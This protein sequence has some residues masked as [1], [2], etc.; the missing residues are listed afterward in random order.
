MYDAIIIGAGMSGLAA[1]IR[2]AHYDQRVCILE[3]HSVIG[4]LN[5]FYRR[6][7]RNFDVGLHA[8]TNYAPKGARGGPLGRLLRQ[9]RLAWDELSLVPQTGSAICF[10]GVSLRFTNDFERLAADVR[11]CF[12]RQED[13]LRRLVASLC[14]YD[15]FADPASSSSARQRV[16]EFIRDP[17]LR[18]M[19]LCP[20]LF[21]GGAR[22]HDIDFGQFSILFRS[23]FLEGLARPLSGVKQI[24]TK[25]V[26]RFRDLGGE[27]RLRCGVR[28]IEV[29]DGAAEKVVLDDGTELAA[30]RIL[31]SAGLHE[32]LR[33]CDEPAVPKADKD[34]LSFVESLSV[35]DTPP[36]ALGHERTIVFFNDSETFH[37]QQPRGAVDLRS[38][39]ICAPSNFAYADAPSENLV[40]ISCLANY[41]LWA[42]M[43][44]EAYR[45]EKLRWFDR[46]AASAARFMPDYRSRVIETD[47]FTPVT[48]ERFT[49]HDRGAVYGAAEKRYDGTTHLKNLFLCGND[50]G[51]VGIVG[52]IL[53]GISVANRHLLPEGLS[54]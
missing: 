53:S 38:G 54:G 24:L 32:T 19:L 14:D 27:L 39:L 6:G 15:R 18:E 50:Q 29:R 31:S 46:M 7:G 23:I 45:L 47:L 34:R 52:A 40:R 16:A 9:L 20:I 30:R 10:P 5:S 25:L 28:R 22:E 37:Y 1:G 3:R 44:P 17:M 36:K 13:G 49:G 21:Y 48:I 26:G 42:G 12:P 11:R 41:D 2:L 8:M 35:L 51:L 4:G 33:L 43:T